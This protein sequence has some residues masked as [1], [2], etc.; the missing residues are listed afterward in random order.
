MWF[1]GLSFIGGWVWVGI[2]GQFL[3]VGG[4]MGIFGK[5][6]WV[7]VILIHCML[8]V[9][10]CM[11]WMFLWFCPCC[12]FA[13]TLWHPMECAHFLSFV[14]P[15]HSPQK[16]PLLSQTPHPIPF[17]NFGLFM[18]HPHLFDTYAYYLFLHLWPCV[19]PNSNV[20][21]LSLYVSASRL[22]MGYFGQSVKH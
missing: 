19:L 10:C 16:I 4:G 17:C 5:G 15:H 9:V 13:M 1:G 3:R 2:F 12:I 11:A 18:L 14:F 6:G 21:V 8:H 20:G 7:I 22:F